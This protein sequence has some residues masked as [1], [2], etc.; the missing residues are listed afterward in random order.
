MKNIDEYIEEAIEGYIE[1]L[2]EELNSPYTSEEEKRAIEK[3]L[4]NFF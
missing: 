3:E 4:L 2:L 1:A